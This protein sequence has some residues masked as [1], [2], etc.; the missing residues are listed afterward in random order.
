MEPTARGDAIAEELRV[1]YE[2]N[3]ETWWRRLWRKPE[4]ADEFMLGL[5]NELYR[6]ERDSHAIRDRSPRAQTQAP[7]MD[8]CSPSK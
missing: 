4:C 1:W 5:I 8:T 2:V 3:R 7:I 6:L